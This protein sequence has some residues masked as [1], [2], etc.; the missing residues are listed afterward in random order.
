[1][2]LNPYNSLPPDAHEGSRPPVPPRRRVR[3]QVIIG[4]ILLAIFIGL[5]CY[6]NSG[7]FNSV[8]RGKVTAALNDATG[9]N[10]SVGA[11]DWNL[12]KLEVDLRDVTVRGKE[13]AD[14]AP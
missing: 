6:L 1:M 9:G 2:A 14:Q 8:V 12:S 4:A 11:L 5:A 7:A 3:L 10:A 13:A